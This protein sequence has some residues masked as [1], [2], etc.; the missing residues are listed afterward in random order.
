VRQDDRALFDDALRPAR[1]AAYP[2]GKFVGQESFMRADEILALAAA[3]GIG[4]GTTVLDLCC[5]VGAPGRLV[6]AEFGC[7]YLG[8]DSCPGA[9]EVARRRTGTLSCRFE[10]RRVPPLPPGPFDVVLLLETLLA[11]PEKRSLFQAVSEALRPGGRFA[12]TVEEGAPMTDAERAVMPDA[13][14]V[15]LT[16]L[17]ELVELLAHAGLRVRSQEECS[18]SHLVTVDA[19]IDSFAAEHRSVTARIGPEALDDLMAAHQLWSTWLREGR[20]RKFAVVAER[21]AT[22]VS[23]SQLQDHPAVARP[24]LH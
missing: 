21:S 7:D 10:V 1:V 5:G 9:V 2:P 3:A 18:R 4:T 22:T 8:V 6:T 20:V 14:T 11:F 15:W 19:L 16:P 13:D 17:A 24:H 12:F 23:G